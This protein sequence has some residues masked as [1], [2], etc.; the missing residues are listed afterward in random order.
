MGTIWAVGKATAVQWTEDRIARRA[1][2]LAFY[3]G[4][5]LAPLLLIAIAIASVVF[6]AEAIRSNI[7]EQLRALLGA[8]AAHAIET[9]LT[10]SRLRGSN[11]LAS[12]L[13]LITF[14]VGASGVFGELQDSMNVIWKVAKKPGRGWQGLVWD[15]LLSF[16]LVLGTGF[17]LLVSVLVSAVVEALLTFFLQRAHHPFATRLVSLTMCFTVECA[18]FAMMFK[19]LP[20]AVT[21]WRDVWLGASITAVLFTIGKG[22]IGLYLG[23]S[24]LASSYGA[25][26]SF[27]VLLIWLYYSCQ[28]F[29]L[30]AEFTH[31]FAQAS[32]RS[33][34]PKNHAVSIEPT[35]TR[36]LPSS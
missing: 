11:A 18:L 13:G 22:F 12:L 4:F 28:I 25:A 3:A 33:P 15:R 27:V 6:N 24:A 1:A 17:L 34:V 20:D 19:I 7:I 5:S 16:S 21:R 26:G 30:G 10:K 31:I 8:E 36:T 9:V 32:G 23:H 14:F 29:L 2:A 35:E